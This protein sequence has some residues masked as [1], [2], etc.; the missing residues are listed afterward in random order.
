[1]K[2]IIS[3]Y[4]AIVSVSTI[5]AGG[6]MTATVFAQVPASSSMPMHAGM[7][8]R[9][10]MASGTMPMR[11]DM[12][13]GSTT[14]M[15]STTREQNLIQHQDQAISNI[16]NRS[17]AEITA[18]INSLNELLVRI[19]AMAKISSSTKSTIASEIQTLSAELATLQSQIQA[20]ASSTPT[21]SVGDLSS[22][23]QLRTEAQSITKDYR[24]Y[25]LVI[26]QTDILA[27]ADRAQT[28][29]TSFTTLAVKLQTRITTLQ[30]AGHDVTALQASLSDLNAKVAD[31]QTQAT[32][33]VTATQSL[34]PDNGNATIAANNATA[35]KAAQAD[36][37]IVDSDIKAATADA[38]S[39]VKGIEA[40]DITASTS[41]ST[42]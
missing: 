4:A 13:M 42:Q 37:K 35:V 15:S 18:R 34:T 1:M 27:A 21:G 22:S 12:R 36:I 7:Y 40:F 38:K 19:N 5:L 3:K 9:G 17:T 26:P 30:T 6:I 8:M 32:A 31:A 25:A 28:L 2:T 24:V 10:H 41:A 29:V 11:A 20:T 16:D 14:R 33:A 23:S 39:I